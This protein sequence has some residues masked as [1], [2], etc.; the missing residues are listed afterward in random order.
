MIHQFH[1]QVYIWK[2]ESRVLERYLC[3]HVNS[4]I[5]HNSQGVNTVQTSIRG[6]M[7]KQTVDYTYN[8]ILALK[9]KEILSCAMA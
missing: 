6:W 2:T 8:G 4:S 9:R 7:E 5:I 1:F 3:I